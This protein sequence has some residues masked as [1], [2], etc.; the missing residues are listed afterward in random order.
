MLPAEIERTAVSSKSHLEPGIVPYCKQWAFFVEDGQ[1]FGKG[2]FCLLLF[3]C[4]NVVPPGS[5]DY[6][7]GLET[8]GE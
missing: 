7:T 1:Q 5:P 8:A 6:G 4:P 2:H 3:L